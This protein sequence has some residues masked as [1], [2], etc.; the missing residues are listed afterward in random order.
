[1]AKKDQPKDSLIAKAYMLSFS[2][3]AF[4]AVA[5]AAIGGITVWQ[6]MAA[7]APSGSCTYSTAASGGV[8]AAT[9]LPKDTVINF[10]MQDKVTGSQTGW[11]LGITHDGTWSV[12]VPAP[13]NATTYDFGSR[14]Y[15]KN[16]AKFNIYAECSIQV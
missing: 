3:L 6:S 15:G 14:T 2:Q 9:G 1:M 5:F 4:F 7:K 12:N 10:F 16:G 11:V 13:A 8:V